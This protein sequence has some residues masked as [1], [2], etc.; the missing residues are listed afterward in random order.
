MTSEDLET[1]VV[2]T[3]EQDPVT[4]VQEESKMFRQEDV[5]KIVAERIQRERAKFEKR[6][7]NVDLDEYNNMIQAKERKEL[8]AKKQ[9]GEFEKILEETV[10]KKDSVI[11]DLQKQV[12]SIK[13]EGAL[14][15]A[16]SSKKAVNPQQVSR[17]LQDRVNL[18]ETGEV[19]IVDDNGAP[20]YGDDGKLLTVDQ[21]VSEWLTS[22]PHFVASTP[23]GSGSQSQT[24]NNTVGNKVDISKLDMSR[25]DHR[26]QYAEWR[27]QRDSAR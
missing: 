22:N 27:K 9:R 5:D 26:E 10:G 17:L 13:V 23:G 18:T 25:K 20:R 2:N 16:A 19:E 4:P 21:Y 14:L 24:A 11:Q 8:E 6:Y 1:P 7:S 3:Q 15:N 12:H